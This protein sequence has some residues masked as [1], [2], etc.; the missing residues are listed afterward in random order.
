[1]FSD[2]AVDLLRLSSSVCIRETTAAHLGGILPPAALVFWGTSDSLFFLFNHRSIVVLLILG[3]GEIRFLDRVGLYP[4]KN[5]CSDVDGS[6]PVA[7]L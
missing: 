6:L 4:G 7:A 2:D 5:R 1:M 3:C